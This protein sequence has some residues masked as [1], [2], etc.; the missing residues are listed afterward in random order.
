MVCSEFF[1][2]W[3]HLVHSAACILPNA[4][5]QAKTNGSVQLF[6]Y[7]SWPRKRTPVPLEQNCTVRVGWGGPGDCFTVCPGFDP[8]QIYARK[9]KTHQS[10]CQQP[11]HFSIS[12]CMLLGWIISPWRRQP[13]R[14][15]TSAQT[16]NMKSLTWWCNRARSDPF[17][18]TPAPARLC[19]T[20]ASHTD[21][22]TRSLPTS[23][24]RATPHVSAAPQPTGC[25]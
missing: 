18:Q 9:I 24:L 8:N 16:H 22:R 13:S 10:R 1:Q 7:S 2:Y 6:Q 25:Y 23:P 17:P 12:M 11:F 20:R 4:V 15:P 14:A 21:A 5:H 19:Q 3:S